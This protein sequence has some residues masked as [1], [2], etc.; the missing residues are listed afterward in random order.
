ML[1]NQQINGMY[2][3]F[4]LSPKN[5]HLLVQTEVFYPNL[6]MRS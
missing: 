2:R 3:P 6:C 5:R 4:E 1:G